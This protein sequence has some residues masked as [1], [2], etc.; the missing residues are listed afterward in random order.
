MCCT[1]QQIG[2]S[3]GRNESQGQLFPPNELTGL[4]RTCQGYASTECG[5]E[6]NVE[7]QPGLR[8]YADNDSKMQKVLHWQNEYIVYITFVQTPTNAVFIYIIQYK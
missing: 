4:D 2:C 6:A 7:F 1:T 8:R 3:Q 5:A